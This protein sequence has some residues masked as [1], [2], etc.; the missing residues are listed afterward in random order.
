MCYADTTLVAIP[1]NYVE[2]D[3]GEEEINYDSLEYKVINILNVSLL[4]FFNSLG[5]KPQLL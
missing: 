3:C 5:V 2:L 1:R 4:G